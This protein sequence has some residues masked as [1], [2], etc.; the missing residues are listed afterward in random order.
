MRHLSFSSILDK[1]KKEEDSIA[2]AAGYLVIFM[3]HHLCS[4]SLL[5][6]LHVKNFPN[7]M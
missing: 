7:K 3:L 6:H 2:N 4:Q 1:L 5:I